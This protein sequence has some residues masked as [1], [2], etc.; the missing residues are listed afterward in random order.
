MKISCIIPA[1]N[2][3]ANIA[4]G[5]RRAW[6]SGC[7]EV[8]VVDGGSTDETVERARV[9][10][11]MVLQSAPG[12]ARQQ[13]LG[14]QQA[15]GDVLYFQHADN[16][17]AA[18]GADQIREAFA[19]NSQAVCGAFVQRIEAAGW[20]YRWLER[21]NAARVRWLGAPYGDQ[22]IFVRRDAFERVGGFPEVKI[23]EELLLM[24]TLRRRFGWPLLLPG[25]LHVNARRW[26]ENGVLRQTLRNWRILTLHAL[27]RKPQ[28]LEELYPRHDR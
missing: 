13:N 7:D 15:A 18:D 4:D 22:G 14:A 3:A 26:R 17:L 23:L 8:I 6:E 1:V 27:G 2:E 21:G 25:P 5:V 10:E 24:R 12:R 9:V 16:W 28:Q 11:C 19:D 20:K